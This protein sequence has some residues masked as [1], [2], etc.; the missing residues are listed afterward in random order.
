VAAVKHVASSLCIACAVFASACSDNGLVGL[1]DVATPLARVQV[2]ITGDVTKLQPKGTESETPHLRAAIVW[3]DQPSQFDA[4][5]TTNQ[6]GAPPG[7]GPGQPPGTPPGL[8]GEASATLVAAAGCRDV[9]GF[10][11]GL[12]GPSIPLGGDVSSTIELMDL[13]TGEVLIGTPETGRIAYA[14]VV[15]FDDRNGNGTLDLR[16]PV[17]Q[18]ANGEG[19]GG[20]GGGGGGPGSEGGG[21]GSGGDPG[22]APAGKGDFVYGASLLTMAAPNTR[23]AF[24]EGGFDPITVAYFYPMFGCA[25]P[26]LGFSLIDVSTITPIEMAIA[27]ATKLQTIP[28][29][30]CATHDLALH[31]A[32]I[33][34]QVT[35]TVRDVACKTIPLRYRRTTKKPDLSLPWVCLEQSVPQNGGATVKKYVEFVIANPPTECKSVTHFLLKGCQQSALCDTPGWDDTGHP[36]EW[37]PCAI[38]PSG[39]TP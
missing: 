27:V 12:V 21:P 11:P 8:P 16:R 3:G 31:A 36:P 19:H 30:S 24:R 35:E 17:V 18:G 29:L 20:G 2:H 37:W 6:F 4:F 23:V 39:S 28:T 14:S 7:G 13:P 34:L 5:C 26:P 38:T 1:V 10:I 32:D 15:V 22:T 9:L 25:P 33:P